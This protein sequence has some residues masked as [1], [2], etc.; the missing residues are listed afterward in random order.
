MELKSRFRLVDLLSILLLTLC[1][2]S[3]VLV[4]TSSGPGISPDSISYVSG[5]RSLAAGNGVLD[6]TGD[7]LSTFPPGLSILMSLLLRV[8][9]DLEVA[10]IALNLIMLTA[11]VALSY[12]LACLTL[13]DRLWAI[14][15]TAV[16]IVSRATTEIFSMVWSEPVFT[17]LALATMILL[18]IGYRRRNV[19]M[20]I[21]CAVGVMTA[22]AVSVRYSGAL[23]VVASAI[24]VVFT[25]PRRLD[26][27]LAR[28]A[29][30][31]AP[32]VIV[33]GVV[34]TLNRA[35]GDGY[36]GARYPSSRSLQGTIQSAVDAI[37]S[38]LIWRGTTSVTILVGSVVV[39]MAVVGAWWGLIRRR[40]SI[41]LAIFTGVYVVGLAVSQ[42]STRLDDASERLGYPVYLP[43]LIL[44]AWGVRVMMSTVQS[45]MH[46][47]WPSLTPPTLRAITITPAVLLAVAIVMVGFVNALRFA[48]QAHDEG[49]GY[50]SRAV[51]QST[52]A[53]LLADIP[54]TETVASNDP[55]L[56]YWLRPDARSLPLPPSPKEWPQER[57]TRDQQRIEKELTKDPEIWGI[58]VSEGSD[59][60]EPIESS[61]FSAN[62][63]TRDESIDG[64]KMTLYRITRR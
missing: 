51:S 56:V 16:F 12:V 25:P 34:G 11:T 38:T 40:S 32:S 1:S 7:N 59:V 47:R 9:L 26:R 6:Y 24:V 45:Q 4:A 8:G 19:S 33:L 39:T 5:A 31:V 46:S 3:L 23:L 58:V 18:V 48:I 22:V 60:R 50:N 29:A 41:V 54:P 37:G 43:L 42:S 44:A 57:L 52:Q 53:R 15:V 13:R 21:A 64:D 28:G 17:P 63:V 61:S 62:V 49:I 2:G 20:T 14:F 55:W 36:F 27:K 35:Q 30:L 10:A